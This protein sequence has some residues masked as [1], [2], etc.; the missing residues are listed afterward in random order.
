SEPVLFARRLLTVH[1]PAART[2]QHLHPHVSS[3]AAVSS[4]G[5]EP[6]TRSPQ[7]DLHSTPS[8][9]TRAALSIPQTP[10]HRCPTRLLQPAGAGDRLVRIP[11]CS[12]RQSTR[13]SPS[14]PPAA[15]AHWLAELIP[16]AL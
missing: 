9:P 6:P 14:Q 16:V 1:S 3:P 2:T 5:P 7:R 13:P 10:A 11:E 12:T 8:R 15:S 4:H